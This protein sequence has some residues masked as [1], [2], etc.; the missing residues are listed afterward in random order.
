[1]PLLLIPV[2]S[3]DK[4]KSRLCGV[5]KAKARRRLNEYFLSRLLIAGADFPGVRQLAVISD[6][7]K[8]LEVARGF[9]AR[10]ILQTSGEGLNSAVTEG[11]SVLRQDSARSILLVACDIP[12]AGAAD[13]QE[14]ARVAQ[15]HDHVVFCP[16]KHGMGTNAIAIPAHAS[17]NF[18]FGEHSLFFH[19]LEARRAGLIPRLYINP[20]IAFDI[21]S[22]EDFLTWTRNTG[23]SLTGRKIGDPK[24][25]DCRNNGRNV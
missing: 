10:T 3:F 2:K 23:F 24:T 20:R 1:M 12:G 13:L 4:G 5:L 19:R 9:G 21:D 7:R 16:D 22:P 8:V 14:L 17:L 15:S 6:C 11:V 18:R 25:D